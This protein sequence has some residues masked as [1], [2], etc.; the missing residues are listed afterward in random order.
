M[1]TTSHFLVGSAT[2]ICNGNSYFRSRGVSSKVN[3]R[4]KRCL[5]ILFFPSNSW[6]IPIFVQN[7][8]IRVYFP[9]T[10]FG[11]NGEIPGFPKSAGYVGT[12]LSAL[13]Q[14]WQR[15]KCYFTSMSNPSLLI[16]VSAMEEKS[17]H[18]S[19]RHHNKHL[20]FM[21]KLP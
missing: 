20:K 2:I 13:T 19:Q 18:S 16:T 8:L 7:H 1:V 11:Y 10:W 9:T 4:L 6:L 14:I 17:P 15:A 12:L 3:I 21:K 5:Q